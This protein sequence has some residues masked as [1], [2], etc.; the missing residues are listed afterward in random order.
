MNLDLTRRTA[1]EELWLWRR[2]DLVETRPLG[3]RVFGKIGATLSQ[4]EAAEVLGIAER[5]IDDLE[6]ERPVMLDEA[7]ALELALC[8]VEPTAGELCRL[9]RRR[10]GMTLDA[11][12]S[13]VHYSRTFTQR[14]R[15]GGCW[16]RAIDL[17]GV[18]R[19]TLLRLER[20]GDPQLV[21][22]WRA[23]GYRFGAAEGAPGGATAAEARAAIG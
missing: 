18:S 13:S 23:R 10:S 19:V 11:V 21:A 7:A 4:R 5:T 12:A 2:S 9:A 8:R 16:Q 20:E 6:R 22:H 3:R 15:G 17:R 1:G 14:V